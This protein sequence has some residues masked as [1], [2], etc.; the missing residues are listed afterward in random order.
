MG[1]IL[2]VHNATVLCFSFQR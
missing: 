1:I 2:F